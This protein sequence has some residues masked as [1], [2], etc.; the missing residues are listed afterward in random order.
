[1]FDENRIL[2][3]DRALIESRSM[4]R[5][6][7]AYLILIP[8]GRTRSKSPEPGSVAVPSKQWQFPRVN[9]ARLLG[10]DPGYPAHSS[11][12]ESR[13]LAC[14][15]DEGGGEKGQSAVVSFGTTLRYCQGRILDYRCR[16]DGVVGCGI[17]QG[18]L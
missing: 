12:C 7:E 13:I 4:G 8:S 17:E 11:L 15:L 10:L 1:L 18:I 5:N 2:V 14:E 16:G 6:R 9:D 3:G